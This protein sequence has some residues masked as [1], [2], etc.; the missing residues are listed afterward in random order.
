MEI[1][2]VALRSSMSLALLVWGGGLL[3]RDLY[4]FGDEPSLGLKSPILHLTHTQTRIA[5][6]NTV[7]HQCLQRRRA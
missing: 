2:Y 5:L 1:F 6:A 4:S 3:K 7:Y